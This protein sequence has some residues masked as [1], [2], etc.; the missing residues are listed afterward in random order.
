[1][2][3]WNFKAGL[4]YNNIFLIIKSLQGYFWYSRVNLL[5]ANTTKWSNKLK[6]FASVFG[7]FVGLA[8]KGL[9]FK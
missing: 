4:F 8:L 5:S 6:Q 9:K 2:I 7:H 3:V 1:M